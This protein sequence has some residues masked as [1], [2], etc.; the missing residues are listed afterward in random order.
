[1]SGSEPPR[2]PPFA[3][4]VVS[5]ASSA[6]LR[7]Y[8][9]RLSLPEGGRLV[10]VD[11]F[12]GDEERA[13][14]RDLA[15]E[16]G[17]EAVLLDRNA[18]FGGGTNAG[19]ARALELGSEVVVGLNPDAAIEPDSLERLVAAVAADP[20]LLASPIV[21]RGSGEPWF[22]G[23]DLYL[24]DGA[25]RGAEA[26][27]RFPDAARLPWATGACFAMSAE[28]WRRLDG[29]DEDYFL[30]WEDIDLSHRALDAGAR[31]GLVDALVVHDAGGTQGTAVA[32]RAKSEEYYYWNIRN[33]ML[34]AVGHLDDEGVRRWLRSAPRA[35]WAVVLRGGRRQLV[36]S[37]RP[38][39]ALVRG[40]RDGARL[41]RERRPAAARHR[42]PVGR[43]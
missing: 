25:T 35:A 21:V 14:V 33:R 36:T 11:C 17:W 5:F 3:V 27:D 26:R 41:A 40:L 19:A 32:D 37:A 6:L 34:Y 38:W 28:L 20:M 15:A 29:F 30:Y 2:L 10:V 24:D 42:V 43:P 7:R 13:R 23:A 39:R 22:A 31:L 4:V 8:A 12:S 16:H 9:A 18:G 1:M